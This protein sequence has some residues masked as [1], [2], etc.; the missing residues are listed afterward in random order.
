MN[1]AQCSAETI[2]GEQPVAGITLGID[3]YY[4]N[5]DKNEGKVNNIS[6]VARPN[7]ITALVG[8]SGS[9]KNTLSL[10][11]VPVN[12]PKNLGIAKVDNYLNIR[13]APGTNEKIV[14]KLPR[15]AGCTVLDVEGD[16]AHIKSG[17]VSGYVSTDYLVTGKKADKLAEKVGSVKITVQESGLFVRTDASTEASI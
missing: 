7:S 5:L 9:G 1:S 2:D 16:W 13:K 8:H 15:N 12:I 4:E 11:K 3:H 10:L 17:K 14:G 6:F